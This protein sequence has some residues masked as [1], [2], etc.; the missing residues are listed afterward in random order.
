[1]K[2]C[3]S[4]GLRLFTILLV[5]ATLV[6]LLAPYHW[7]PDL[8]ANL[9][10]QQVLA[11]LVAQV[12][13]VV[14]RQRCWA[15]MPLGCLAIH[16]LW[17]LPALN[18]LDEPP[19]RAERLT[20]TLANVLTQNRQHEKVIRDLLAHEPDVIIILE[21]GAALTAKLNRCTQADYP[22][23][24]L[25]PQD[26]GNFGIGLYSRHPIETS[27][28]FTLNT[29]V[30]SIAATICA[31]DGRYQIVA[32][33]PVP[34]IGDTGY[35]LRNEH[36]RQLATMLHEEAVHAPDLPRV[37]AGDLNLTPWSPHFAGFERL[38]GL[39]RAGKGLDFTPTWYR[40]PLFPF[41]LVLDHM[42]IS[43]NLACVSHTI[44]PDIG[45]DHR[46]VT[47]TVAPRHVPTVA[48]PRSLGDR[49]KFN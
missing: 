5:A 6:T 31:P 22:H 40:Y 44:G 30:E 25:R 2:D 16:L 9:R 17:F 27:E 10:L 45:S 20:I 32:T 3:L 14:H 35:R 48:F 11:L 43:P 1:M 49:G 19:L 29:S 37:L 8:L 34:P 13:W 15:V 4:I 38:S 46:S 47:V 24:I 12:M 33:H 36:L 41:G 7:L 21:L 23:R 39:Q 28:V 26:R 42:L 18:A